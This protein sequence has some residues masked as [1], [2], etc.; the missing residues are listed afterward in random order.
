MHEL[1][2]LYPPAHSPKTVVDAIGRDLLL[3]YG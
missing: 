2:H 3:T 1:A